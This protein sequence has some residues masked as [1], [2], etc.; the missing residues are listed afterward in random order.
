[1]ELGL[2]LIHIHFADRQTDTIRNKDWSNNQMGTDYLFVVFLL[3]LLIHSTNIYWARHCS[4]WGTSSQVPGLAFPVREAFWMSRPHLL[5]LFSHLCPLLNPVTSG[6][7]LNLGFYQGNQWLPSLTPLLFTLLN[8]SAAFD[9]FDYFL[10]TVSSVALSYSM[11]FFALP[12]SWCIALSNSSHTSF[13]ACPLNVLFFRVLFL[14]F[15]VSHCALSLGNLI[16]SHNC[17]LCAHYSQV[18]TCS[19]TSLLGPRPHSHLYVT[20]LQLDVSQLPPT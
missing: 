15:L 9:T 5:S 7:C 3:L 14:P 1:M 10:D 4:L 6:F 16:L 12:Y 13:S 17:N 20:H 18:Y 11:L 8:I 2:G 19:F